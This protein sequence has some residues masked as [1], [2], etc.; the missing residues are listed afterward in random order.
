MEKDQVGPDSMLPEEVTAVESFIPMKVS[1]WLSWEV[2]TGPKYLDLTEIL[3]VGSNEWRE[4]PK[5]PMPIDDVIVVEDPATNSLLIVSGKYSRKE[6]KVT[7]NNNDNHQTE[8]EVT[9]IYRLT[10]P[11][12]DESRWEELPQKIKVGRRQWPVAFFIP[13]YL[14]DCQ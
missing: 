7:V 4:G 8:A 11:I 10:G 12:S 13:D 14:T 3:E 5:L 6:T 2:T 1:T 9:S